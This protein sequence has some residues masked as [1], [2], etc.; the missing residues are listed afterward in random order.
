MNAL[1]NTAAP[2]DEGGVGDLIVFKT[3]PI[4]LLWANRLDKKTGRLRK[5]PIDVHSQGPGDVSDARKW[6]T[7]EEAQARNE[8]IDK[9]YGG[10][11]GIVLGDHGAFRL[12]GM[13]LDDCRNAHGG[14]IAPWAQEVIDHYPGYWEIS[15]SQTGFKGFFLIEGIVG[16]LPN[17]KVFKMKG[18]DPS[19][20]HGPQ[21]EFYS[22][23]RWFAVTGKKY[24][25]GTC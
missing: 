4:W 9:P 16:D 20:L 14:T 3:N 23:G 22:A 8:R 17:S 10:G 2:S 5:I 13:D 18:R 6:G 24:G 11:L 1:A 15:P 21:I 25:E 7:L 19:V 12:G